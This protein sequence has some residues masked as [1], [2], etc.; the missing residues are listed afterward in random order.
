MKTR[1]IIAILLLLGVLGVAVCGASASAT[2]DDP[3]SSGPPAEEFET[4]PQ[5]E[6]TV[7]GSSY[8]TVQYVDTPRPPFGDYRW[9]DEDFGWLHTFDLT[10]KVLL[11]VTLEIRAWD[12]D[13]PLPG[14]SEYYWERDKVYVD[15]NYIGELTGVGNDWSVTA[16]SIDPCLAEAMLCDGKMDVWLDIDAGG[17]G[18]REP[19]SWAVTIDWSKLT[20]EWDE[21]PHRVIPEL[22]LGT[23]S[24]LLVSLASLVVYQKR[25]VIRR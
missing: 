7:S 15:G 19:G 3:S 12:V 18:L 22:P 8:T 9:W 24:A 16:F 17:P 25:R 11:S 1:A 13:N 10:G 23:I 14:Y 6:Y 2:G 21:C 5:H 20:V 4:I